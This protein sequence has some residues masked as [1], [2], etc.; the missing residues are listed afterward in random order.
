MNIQICLDIALR[1]IELLAT[2]RDSLLGLI[3]GPY[4][5][6]RALLAASRKKS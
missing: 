6:G 3:V 5:S 4:N 1:G 2:R